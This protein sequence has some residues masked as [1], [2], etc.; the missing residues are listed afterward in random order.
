M[1]EP[2]VAARR[3]SCLDNPVFIPFLIRTRDLFPPSCCLNHVTHCCVPA[4][5]FLL[6]LTNPPR[7]LPPPIA[8]MNV[9]SLMTRTTLREGLAL[10]T[11]ARA[12]VATTVRRIVT[13]LVGCVLHI[14]WG[15]LG[16]MT[17][18]CLSGDVRVRIIL[19]KTRH[20]SP[21]LTVRLHFAKSSCS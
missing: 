21:L 10:G 6:L 14:Q 4:S 1:R 8:A 16:N 19:G 9:I 2:S 20:A 11:W 3:T 12:C 7:P 18:T 15:P 13:G 17:M 5:C